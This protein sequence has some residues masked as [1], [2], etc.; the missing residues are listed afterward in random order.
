MNVDELRSA[1][2]AACDEDSTEW[3]S[4]LLSLLAAGLTSSVRL[5]L[6]QRSSASR[7]IDK[8]SILNEL[9]TAINLRIVG[10]LSG[11]EVSPDETF[12]DSL[13]GLARQGDCEGELTTAVRNLL[14]V[15]ALQQLQ[16]S[17]EYLC[18][19]A[20]EDDQID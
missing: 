7:I 20:P 15:L 1:L 2:L 13:F 9:Q 11:E 18:D 8:L 4:Y 6:S 17:E 19:Q 10:C 5:L 14:S 16:F 3:N 12:I